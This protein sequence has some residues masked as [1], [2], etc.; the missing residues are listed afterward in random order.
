MALFAGEFRAQIAIN[1][2]KCRIGANY[3]RSEHQNVHV[4]VFD[5]L[6]S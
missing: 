3:P 6:A 4:V 1:Q 2:I 5:A